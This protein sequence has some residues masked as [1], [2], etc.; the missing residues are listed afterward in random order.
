MAEKANGN[1]EY[2]S[3]FTKI[4]ASLPVPERSNPIIVINIS[5]KDEPISW[6]MAYREL[7]ENSELGKKIGRKLVEL[8]II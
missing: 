8:S 6:N 5:G 2:L 3:R 4:Y 1:E 7:R